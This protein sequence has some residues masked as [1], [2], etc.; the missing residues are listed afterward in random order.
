MSD[1]RAGRYA[2]SLGINV[3]DIPAFLLA[4]RHSGKTT[5][6]TIQKLIDALRE[7]D[8]YGFSKTVLDQLLR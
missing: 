8:H 7:K 6:E 3:V 1:R 2:R 5:V 4:Y